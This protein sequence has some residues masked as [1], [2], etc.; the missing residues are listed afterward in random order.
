MNELL[1][2]LQLVG[3]YGAVIVFYKLFGKKGLLCWT[4]IATV[5]ANIEVLLQVDAFGMHMT[6]GNVL[7][8][9]SFVVT[10]ILSELYGQSVSKQA[11]NIGICTSIIFI[12]ICQSWL[13]FE[14]NVFDF[15]MP[16][17]IVIFTNTPRLIFASFIVYMIVQRL[18]VWL[19]H[20]WWKFTSK[21]FK[22]EY[23]GLW[24]RNNGSTLI[25]QLLNSILYTILAFYGIM[26]NEVLIN[27]IFTSYI[28][29][30]V[31]S[32]ADTPVVYICRTLKQK[33][34]ISE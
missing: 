6:L 10:D 26:E 2:I 8:A 22:D 28:I 9:T 27:L 23:K 33:G 30:I 4:V 13:I 29:F 16:S 25:S 7:F 32:I 21:I 15:A 19:Y 12:L 3:L 20:K 5:L 11:V 17:F 1:L 24:M 14:P 18:D 34:L 31:T